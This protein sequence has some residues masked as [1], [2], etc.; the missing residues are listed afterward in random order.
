MLV[1]VNL[2]VDALFGFFVFFFPA[3]K[4]LKAT[5]TS[6]RAVT[7]PETAAYPPQKRPPLRPLRD[8]ARGKGSGGH[9]V[10]RQVTMM[11]TTMWRKLKTRMTKMSR[12]P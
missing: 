3:R 12:S 5:M 9:A 2:F 11:T 4:N 10:Q 8:P 7:A 6:L 1:S